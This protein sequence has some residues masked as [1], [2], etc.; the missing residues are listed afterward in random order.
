MKIAFISP[1]TFAYPGGVKTHTFSLKKEFEK[2]G[3]EV[4]LILPRERFPQKKD[5]DTILLGGALY[6]PG[7]ASRTN[8]TFSLTPLSIWQKLKKE[9]FDILH[10]QNFGV[11]LPWQVLEVSGQFF[12]SPLKILT[13]HALWDASTLFREFPAIVDILNEYI[14]PRLDGII[15]VSKP[16]LDQ[17]KYDGPKEII[18]NGIDLN[19][20]RPGGPK[21]KKFVVSKSRSDLEEIINILFVGRIEKRK[22]LRYLLQAFSRLK[23]KYKNLQLIVVGEGMRLKS[24][25]DF[26]KKNKIQGIF[27]EGEVEEKDLPKYYRTADIC[28]FPS[29][30]GEAFGI[31]L[32]EAMAT[33]RPI[34]AF[35]NKGYREVLV[36][37]SREFLVEPKN[38]EILIKKLEILIEDKKKREELG[39]WGKKEVRKYSWPMVAQR[40]LKFYN[41]L[42]EQ[43]SS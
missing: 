23:K 31:V 7:N 22:G 40:I 29:I 18:P 25:Q 36:G 37:K 24:A 15:G 14:L 41:K 6:I 42:I 10:F 19:F 28:C 3:H 17:I 32:L 34:V 27:F 5:K 13:L 4:K 1:Y 20:F 16:V 43:K 33:A 26:V 39:Q 21:I 9:N 38:I 8:L 30:Y 11:F 35:A 12:P 2:R